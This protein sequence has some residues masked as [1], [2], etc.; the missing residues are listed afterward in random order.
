MSG[1]ARR[2]PQRTCVG[3]REATAKRQLRRVVRTPEG[4][5]AVDPSGRANGRGAYVHDSAE[6]W[7][8]ALQRDAL[9][10][11][12]RTTI[13]PEDRASLEAYAGALPSEA[14]SPALP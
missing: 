13:S 8:D 14:P 11:A 2:I 6:C 10:R 9:G 4:G 7:R 5:V 3:C 1:K 12:L